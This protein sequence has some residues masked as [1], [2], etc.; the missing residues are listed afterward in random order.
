MNKLLNSQK[1]YLKNITIILYDWLKIQYLE[2]N[3][4]NKIENKFLFFLRQ[5]ASRTDAC[6]KP[7][8]KKQIETQ[9][10]VRK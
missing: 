9:E 6:P 3:L 2:I 7:K 4:Y 10:D 1:N 5:V 8:A